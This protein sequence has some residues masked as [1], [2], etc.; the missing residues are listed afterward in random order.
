MTLTGLDSLL[1]GKYE[2]YA[3][4]K[5]LKSGHDFEFELSVLLF[6]GRGEREG[7]QVL[8]KNLEKTYPQGLLAGGVKAVQGVSVGVSK[9]QCFGLLGVNGAGKTSV[10][11]IVTG[12]KLVSAILCHFCTRSETQAISAS[13]Q[14]MLS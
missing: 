14:S 6:A 13:Y 11:R 5:L 7:D 9:G 10:F 12:V 1:I 2:S 4:H 3:G 8:L